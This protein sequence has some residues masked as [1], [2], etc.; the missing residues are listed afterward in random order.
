MAA[1]E[2]HSMKYVLTHRTATTQTPENRQDCSQ[3]R[4]IKRDSV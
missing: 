2:V 4:H 3:A 1:S